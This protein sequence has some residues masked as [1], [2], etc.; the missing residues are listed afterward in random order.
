MND[1]TQSQAG[2]YV[3]AAAII[4]AAVLL[5]L[6]LPRNN[7]CCCCQR[8]GPAPATTTTL[9]ELGVAIPP[10]HGYVLP[11]IRKA[12]RPTRHDIRRIA[13]ALPAVTIAPVT[14]MLAGALP[15]QP[16]AGYFVAY[17][18]L[19][20]AYVYEP[21]LPALPPSGGHV[22]APHV[23]VD[24]AGGSLGWLAIGAGITFAARRLA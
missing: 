15:T 5:I 24:E 3:V 12:A 23:S 6:F 4:L 19:D 2:H 16:D 13:S 1:R 8:Q 7:C 18:P 9:H 20:S 22:S 10:G 21:S 17:E 11:G 14:P